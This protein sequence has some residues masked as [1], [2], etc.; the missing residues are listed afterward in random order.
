MRSPLGT[1]LT[2]S[3]TAKADRYK[4]KSNLDYE[5]PI[6]NNIGPGATPSG[7]VPQPPDHSS[8]FPATSVA[9]VPSGARGGQENGIRVG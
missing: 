8:T 5:Q 9:L 6:K 7:T 2:N 1:E 3:P 4:A